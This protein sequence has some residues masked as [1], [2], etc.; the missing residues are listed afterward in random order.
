MDY[1]EEF[2]PVSTESFEVG[3]ADP[4]EL[5]EFNCIGVLQRSVEKRYNDLMHEAEIVVLREQL[6]W[7]RLRR[8]LHVE[9]EPHVWLDKETGKVSKIVQKS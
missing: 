9:D 2:I 1:L 7:K 8:R 6:F 3:R 5:E 4:S